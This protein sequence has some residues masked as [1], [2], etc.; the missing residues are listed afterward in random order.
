[1]KT[2]KGVP[3]HSGEAAHHSVTAAGKFGL[4][5]AMQ[6]WQDIASRFVGGTKMLVRFSLP[7]PE[8]GPKRLI[9][10]N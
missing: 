7:P 5:A 10:S 9:P 4:M 2:V 8:Y 3:S 6:F 1:M